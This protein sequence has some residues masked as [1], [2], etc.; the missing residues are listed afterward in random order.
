MNLKNFALQP[1]KEVNT[2]DVRQRDGVH[3]CEGNPCGELGENLKR[4]D[5][6]SN[7]V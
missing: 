3:N 5:Q 4:V 1:K 6:R 7:K 2:L